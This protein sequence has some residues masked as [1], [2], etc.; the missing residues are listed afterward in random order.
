MNPDSLQVKPFLGRDVHLPEDGSEPRPAYH[1]VLTELPNRD[2]FQDRFRQAIAQAK[3]SGKAVGKLCLNLGGLRR[4]KETLGHATVD[5]LLQ[6]TAQRLQRTVR[7]TDTVAR[8]GEAEFAIVLFELRK[9][10]DAVLVARKTLRAMQKPFTIGGQNLFVTTSVGISVF[11]RHGTEI[12]ELMEKAQFAMN[13]VKHGETDNYQLYN[14]ATR[15]DFVDV[16][17][18]EYGL[19]RAL[20]GGE[21][22]PYFQP[23]VDCASGEITGMEAFVRWRHPEF[24]I[25]SAANF[26]PVAEE[27]GIIVSIDKWM[28]KAACEQIKRW[29]E[30]GYSDLKISVNLSARQFREK[31]LP[32]I[33]SE[34]LE[35]A[36]LEPPNL[37]LE[38]AETNVM[39]NVDN[40]VALFRA[41]KDRGIQLS[42]DDFGTGHSSLNCLKRIPLDILKVDRSFVK[43]IPNNRD[44]RAVTTAAVALAHCLGLKV[45]VEGIENADQSNF[46]SSLKCD[47]MQGFYFSRPLN[48]KTVTALLE[49][50]TRL[51]ANCVQNSNILPINSMIEDEGNGPSPQD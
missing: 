13:C 31:S 5:R 49:S 6:Q 18:V 4:I 50:G 27:T 48:A 10:E 35:E 34:I 45:V 37:C 46:L 24:G 38:V 20:D 28:L 33:I 15:S 29:R 43:G 11:P 19:R 30:M 26:V 40:T 51:P 17:S 23:L 14:E 12:K 42:I 1:D 9:Q 7:G 44:N 39:Q 36:G 3:R 8:L 21:L 32:W 25:I 2:L 22:V 47:E 41:L 16:L